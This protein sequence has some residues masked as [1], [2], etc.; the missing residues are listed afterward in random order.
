RGAVASR[1][2][3]CALAG[4]E[5]DAHRRDRPDALSSAPG[6]ARAHRVRR[7]NGG[8]KVLA[9]GVRVTSKGG[10][11]GLRKRLAYL[12]KHRVRV[13]VV[14]KKADD[15][16]KPPSYAEPPDNRKSPATVALVAAAHEYGLGVPMRS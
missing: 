6:G 1:G 13:G 9:M 16:K 2:S 12:R 14:G 15:E 7:A 11:D 3:R 10:S 5:R 4:G 8:W